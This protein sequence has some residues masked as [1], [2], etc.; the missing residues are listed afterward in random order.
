MNTIEDLMKEG[1][2]E[3]LELG[4]GRQCVL[5]K[6]DTS[7]ILYNWIEEKIILKYEIR[8]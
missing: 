8:K 7:R 2:K 5:Y 1:W 6:K 3:V 4:F